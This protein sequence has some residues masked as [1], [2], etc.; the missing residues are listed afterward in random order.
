M[1][2][3]EEKAYRKEMRA[4]PGSKRKIMVI[5]V[6]FFTLFA[7]FGG[8]LTVLGTQ[9]SNGDTIFPNVSILGIDVGGLTVEE[10]AYRVERTVETEIATRT[11]RVEFPGGGYLELTAQ[12]AGLQLDGRDAARIAYSHGRRGNILSNSVTFLRGQIRGVD[13][14]P[15]RMFEVNETILR[16]TIEAQTEELE[17]L[18]NNFYEIEGDYLL[19][20][21]GQVR[22]YF[23]Q[24]EVMALIS[25][26][27][28]AGDN[29][30]VVYHANMEDPEPVN[31]EE[32]YESVFREAENAYF[33]IETE[34][35][36]EHTVGIRFEMELAQALL[37]QAENG[38]RVYIPLIINEPEVTSDFLREVLFRDVLAA[39]TTRLTTDENRNTNVHLAASEINGMILNPGDQFD[40]NTVVQ[41]RTTERGFRPAGAFSGTT[42]IQSVGGGICQVSSTIYHALLHT[43]IQIDRR[44][45]HTLVV[46]YLPLGM[47]SAV[48]WGGPEFTFTNSLDFPIRIVA[49]RDGLDF[50]V[51][52]E[53]TH[54]GPYYRI[55]PEGVYIGSVAFSTT[56]RDY[57]G[58]TRGETRVETAG[59]VGHVVDVF[60]RFY[61]SEGNLVRR[62]FVAR[63]NYHPVPQVVLRGTAQAPEPPPAA[64]PPPVD[65]PPY[66]PGPAY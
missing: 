14:D 13:L 11:V 37:N 62:E 15:L 31:L 46:T 43:E 18:A 16:Q 66:E 41:R 3:K 2:K 49:Y 7:L 55:E 30:P 34:E 40:F 27:F 59:R 32:I 24:D 45:N 22:V 26:A 58:L 53:G 33:I 6:V 47:D 5:V 38:E 44:I 10:A 29:E 36:T 8:G 56:Y 12:E 25:Q 64:P 57:A 1:T 42:V 4:K 28:L 20:V 21:K 17:R 52:I 50:V 63:S 23:D 9:V 48:A 19:I 54:T 51:R 35:V 65:P 61:D 39:S 60:Q